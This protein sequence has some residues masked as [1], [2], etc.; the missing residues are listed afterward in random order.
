MNKKKLEKKKTHRM[1]KEEEQ[2][3]ATGWIVFL[4]FIIVG[5]L[6]YMVY[7]N[8]PKTIFQRGSQLLGIKKKSPLQKM[9]YQGKKFLKSVGDDT[10]QWWSKM[11]MKPTSSKK[12][13]AA[14]ST[15]YKKQ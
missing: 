10:H 14:S 13:H 12:S 5:V 1:E 6:L 9:G 2:H 15:K 3:Y 4:L 7:Q 11:S 8:R